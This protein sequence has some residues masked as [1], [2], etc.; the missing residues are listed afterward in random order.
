MLRP[1]NY[2]IVLKLFCMIDPDF[3][4]LF[5]SLFCTSTIKCSTVA[6][7]RILA[8]SSKETGDDLGCHDDDLDVDSDDYG[9]DVAGGLD[10]ITNVRPPN[11]TGPISNLSMIV[12]Q[13]YLV[14]SD[15]ELFVLEP[16]KEIACKR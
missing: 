2:V 5:L 14:P 11:G 6:P 15:A 9:Q 1:Q 13:S 12:E 4:F 3:R 7:A 8:S 16:G 10:F